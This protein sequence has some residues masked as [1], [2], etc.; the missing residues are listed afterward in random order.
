M[1][2]MNHL[3]S[4]LEARRRRQESLELMLTKSRL[5]LIILYVGLVFWG[6]QLIFSVIFALGGTQILWL[7]AL[8]GA[9]GSVL[10]LY[11]LKKR[12]NVSRE[13]YRRSRGLCVNCGYDL[14]GSTDLCPECGATSLPPLK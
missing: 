10:N 14:R 4:L 12:G 11:W 8:I 13:E 1:V 3:K 7:G 9:S 6:S 2:A 5:G